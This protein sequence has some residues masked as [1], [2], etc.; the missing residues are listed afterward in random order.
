MLKRCFFHLRTSVIIFRRYDMNLEEFDMNR[1]R[2]VRQAGI[3]LWASTLFLALAGA[4]PALAGTVPSTLVVFTTSN[5]FN[6]DLQTQ[7]AG[8]DGLDGGDN[9]CQAAAD[10]AAAIVPAGIYK[11]WGSTASVD[12]KD[13]IASGVYVRSDGVKVADSLVDLLDGSLLAAISHDEFGNPLPLNV[14]TG[15]K[16]DGTLTDQADRTCNDWTSDLAGGA[17]GFARLG[18]NTRSDFGW[19]DNTNSSSCNGL[20]RIYCFQVLASD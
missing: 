13:R 2:P 6:G 7:G 11:F 9:L 8:T 15:T 12:A 4:G 19:T 5:A 14:W 10:A 17:G 18:D 20:L 3:A 16:T 1:H